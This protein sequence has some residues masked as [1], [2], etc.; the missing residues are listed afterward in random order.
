MSPLTFVLLVLATFV[1]FC[2]GLIL[3]AFFRVRGE[4]FIIPPEERG[5]AGAI[6]TQPHLGFGDGE[7]PGGRL[8]G[9]DSVHAERPAGTL[10]KQALTTLRQWYVGRECAV[11]RREIGPV[12]ITEPRPGLLNVASPGREILSWDDI[13]ADHLEAVLDSHL[14]V[15]PSCNFAESFRREFPERVIDRDDPT[16]REKAYH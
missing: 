2:G 10:G 6:V 11:C 1:L 9:T 4:P 15:C 12:H 7:S 14:P 8:A 5:V 16:Q 13:P 3:R